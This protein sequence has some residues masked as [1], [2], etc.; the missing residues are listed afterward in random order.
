ME[1][2]A[3]GQSGQSATVYV[4]FIQMFVIRVFILFLAVCQEI[5]SACSFV[6]FQNL[7]YMPRSFGY[8]VLQ[9][10]LVI[11]EIEMCPSVALAPLDKLLTT[12]DNVDRASFL[13]GIHTFFYDRNYRILTYGICTYVYTVKISA[14]SCHKETIVVALPYRRTELHISLLF[15]YRLRFQ[16]EPL[17][18]PCRHLYFL[19]GVGCHI[20]DIQMFLRSFHFS[21]HLIFVGF[22]RWTRLSYG[23]D[24]PQRLH[25]SVIRYYRYEML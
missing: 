2:I 13:I 6:Y 3:L 21:R 18:L 22:E 16:S 8:T 23:I 24:Y 19:T 11:I 17:V 5:Y 15:L 9:I 10:S 4:Y 25:S 12:V 20:E 1:V 14:V 7:L